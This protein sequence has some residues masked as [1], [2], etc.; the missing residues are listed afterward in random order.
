MKIS[1]YNKLK[2][3]LHRDMGYLQDEVTSMMT[4]ILPDA[5]LHGGTSIWRCYNGNRFSEDLDYYLPEIKEKNLETIIR[6]EIE[7]RGL[8]I[9]KY[10]ET[11]NVIFSKITDNK[12]EIRLEIRIIMKNDAVIK[13]AVAREYEK[14]D[15]STI[16]IQTLSPED[17]LIEKANAFTNRRLIRD[18]YDVYFLSNIANIDKNTAKQLSEQLSKFKEAI[19]E[20]NLKTIIISGIIPT[21]KQMLDAI[22]RRTST[23]R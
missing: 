13:K 11:N 9:N 15:G 16:T 8:A 3:Q 10:K 1:I 20:N 23:T 22:K 14:I 4:E 17:L 2:K 18:I 5:I 21:E 12:V 7:K 19:D 6:K